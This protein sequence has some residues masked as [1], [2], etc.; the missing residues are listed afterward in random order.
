MLT[1]DQHAASP[2]SR[3]LNNSFQKPPP[4]LPLLA[5][6]SPASFPRCRPRQLLRRNGARRAQVEIHEGLKQPRSCSSCGGSHPEPHVAKHRL[7]GTENNNTH[8][9]CTIKN[10]STFKHFFAELTWLS[11]EG[12]KT[13]SRSNTE[14]ERLVR[15]HTRVR[16]QMLL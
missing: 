11:A 13:R 5:T 1:H 3:D 12:T 14:F 15:T 6:V 7:S 9:L 8:T 10:H 16:T 2:I 4:T